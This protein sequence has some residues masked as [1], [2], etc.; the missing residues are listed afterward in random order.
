MLTINF[1]VILRESVNYTQI[2]VLIFFSDRNI[3]PAIIFGIY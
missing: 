3:T 2:T 1:L